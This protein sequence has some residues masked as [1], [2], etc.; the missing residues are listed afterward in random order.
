MFLR[1]RDGVK[2]LDDSRIEL[3]KVKAAPTREARRFAFRML[4]GAVIGLV[5]VAVAILGLVGSSAPIDTA[6]DR[7]A[8][9]LAVEGVVKPVRVTT[10]AWISS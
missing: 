4:V 8:S 10:R 9:A 2:R 7:P 3:D 1:L 6:P 5:S